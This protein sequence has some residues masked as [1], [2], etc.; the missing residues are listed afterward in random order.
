MKLSVSDVSKHC[1]SLLDSSNVSRQ[2]F[3]DVEKS[4]GRLISWF[5]PA[6]PG[7]R[8]LEAEIT[9]ENTASFSSDLLPVKSP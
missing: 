3:S 1:I 4:D 2:M 9:S 8:L 7:A 5:R 6:D